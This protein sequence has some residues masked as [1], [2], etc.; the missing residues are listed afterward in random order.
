M[1]DIVSKGAVKQELIPLSEPV[2]WKAALRDIPH[3][4]GHTQESCYAMQL[5]T[6]YPTYLYVF[7]KD[8]V[9]IVCPLAERSYHGYTDVVTPYGFSGLT[10]NNNFPGFPRY[11]QNFLSEAG[12][13]CGY[14]GLNPLLEKETYLP[15]DD[16]YPYNTLYVLDLQL[17]ISELFQRLSQNR[18]RQLKNF[19]S[20][21]P[22][23]TTDKILLKDFFISR[24]HAFVAE[25]QAAP[26]YNFSR[27]TL[28]YLLDLDNVLLVGFVENGQVRAVS[29]FAYT[30]YT[31]EYLFNVS[32]P[33]AQDQTAA[34]LWYGVKLLK[35]KNIPYLNLGGGVKAGDSLAQF[36]QRFGATALP[37][38]C[39]KEVFKEPVYHQLCQK[40]Q[41]DPADKEGYFPA[42]RRP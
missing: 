3:A 14:I 6:G 21:L 2:K 39:L 34:L 35:S 38:K 37:L 1:E 25:K 15:A 18:R 36:K 20:I 31:G 29:V 22:Q 32:L 11:W 24:Y 13:V 7:Q 9:K 16:V 12:Y 41:V 40:A 30:T 4:F 8:D 42:Y 26:V 10:G 27:P 17:T 23:F 28:S 33:G 19:D 5:T